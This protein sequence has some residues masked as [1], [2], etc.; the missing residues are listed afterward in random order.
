MTVSQVKFNCVFSRCIKIF[1]PEA[2]IFLYFVY[3]VNAAFLDRKIRTPKPQSILTP[4]GLEM[5][6]EPL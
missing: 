3:L 1:I 2:I 4:G 5:L 6:F